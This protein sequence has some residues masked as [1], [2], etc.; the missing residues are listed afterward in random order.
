MKEILESKF[1][2]NREPRQKDW[3][4]LIDES[5]SEFYV[6]DSEDNFDVIRDDIVLTPLRTSMLLGTHGLEE[7]FESV[8]V[9]SEIEPAVDE[10]FEQKFNL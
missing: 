3:H 7:K 4:R 1:D 9:A 10:I 5:K 2:K 6:A 8:Y